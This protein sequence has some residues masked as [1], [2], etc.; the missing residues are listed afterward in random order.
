MNKSR[1]L[2]D[3]LDNWM[4]IKNLLTKDNYKNLIRHH[5]ESFDNFIEIKI[6]QIIKQ[7][8][9]LSIYHEYME[10]TNSYKYEIKINFMEINYIKPTI[11]ENDGSTKTM[12]PQDARLRN[13]TYSQTIMVDL[14]IEIVQNPNTESAKTLI[15]KRLNNINIGKVPVMVNSKFC[16][17]NNKLQN[18]EEGFYD[19]G[20][21]FII[22]GNEKVIVNQEKIAENKIY[23]FESTK[24][25]SKYSHICEI[26]SVSSK[27]FNTPKNVSVKLLSRE[28]M[29]G[30]CVRINIPH[31]KIEI[32]VFIVFKALG[33]I[34][35]KDIISHIVYNIGKED[36]ALLNWLR[37]NVEEASHIKTQEEA[38]EYLLRNGLILG[39][40]K[41]IKLDKDRKIEIFKAMLERDL[42][43]HI[44]GD[45]K[46][47]ALFL[48]YMVYKLGMC[49]LN[50]FKM[51]DRDNYCNK[52]I[53]SS[54]HLMA[55]LFRQYF[56][57]LIKDMRNSIMKELNSGP[58]K[59]TKNIEAVINSTNLFKMLKSTTLESGL[60]Y[61]LSTGNWGIKSTT[62]K[63]G[64]AQV[65]SR[66]TYVSTI[67]HLR[68]VNTPTE[69]TGKL[70]A[71][72]K[73]HNTQWGII[74]APETPEGGSVGLV[75]NLALST[76]ISVGTDKSPVIKVL[77]NIEDYINL[78]KF[79]EK[80]DI[81]DLYQKSKV[82]IN[83]EWIGV[84]DIPIKLYKKLLYFKRIGHINI[85]SSIS[86][87]HEINQI[88]IFTDAGRC[89][90]PLYIVENN[91]LKIKK[92]DI[93]KLHNNGYGINN[94][95]VKTLD[96][97]EIEEGVIEYVDTEESWNTM[98]ASNSESLNSKTITY[99]YCEIHPCLILGVLGSLIP[100]CNNNQSPRNTYQ[101]AMGK[102]AMGIYAT[103]FRHRM[104][105]MGHIL[106]YPQKP[107][108]NTRIANYLPTNYMPNG[109]NVIVAIAS[110]SG[111]NQE[112]SVL[113]KKSAVERGLFRST[114]YRTYKD[115]EKK[116]Q[117]S[118]QEEKFTIPDREL[119]KGMK[120]GCY[121][122]LDENGFVK[123]NKYVDTDDI[124][125]GKVIPLRKTNSK[126][127]YKDASTLLRNN[128]AGFVDKI[129]CNRNGDGH[130]FCKIRIRSER[131][132]KIGDKFSSRHGQKG[133]VGMIFNDEDMP[134]TK[135][136]ITPDVII[137]PH[138]IPSRM[139]I[140]QLIE[141]LL[142]KACSIIGCYGDGT[143]FSGTDINDISTI[144]KSYKYEEH[145]NEI[146]YDGFT[147]K[148]MSTKIFIGPTYYQRLKHMV[149]DKVH[150]RSTGPMVL[151]TRQPTEG[152]T[153]EG[154]LR[155][156]EMERD[157]MIAHGS[158]MFL[159]E[160]M[161][162]ISDNY[163]AFTCNSC[164]LLGI[165]NPEKNVYKCKKCNNYSDFSEIRIPYACKLM[166]QELESMSVAPRIITN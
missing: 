152:R 157:C 142:G 101:C 50:K 148:Q 45:F 162:D 153:R 85:Y 61:G 100:F 67:S 81:V 26:K 118:D 129:Y 66:I 123:L 155:F 58:W 122:K 143:P 46:K 95:V 19:L 114:F 84:T 14:N 74:C 10:E 138:A 127:I 93:D 69:K 16:M 139:T 104:D 56:T 17:L 108:V 30:R 75:K 98:I 23:V 36:D 34:S 44:G 4:V 96:S 32:P 82:F 134:Y 47:K 88:N 107:M 29:Y 18:K 146:L 8:N 27:G 78:D 28:N 99:S 5:I 102:Q 132:P 57:K 24:A 86:F 48:G 53:E 54:G 150:S 94:L 62:T 163:R 116:Y 37:P 137:N 111:Y 159:K 7:L 87:S 65:L 72:R 52:R 115:D 70:V 106:N 25:S 131:I 40:P 2:I 113:L 91:K 119:T 140:A 125:I 156:G 6:P 124:V 117:S 103:N 41:D 158:L 15:V 38:L 76:Y 83:G 73:L 105:T 55:L 79:L 42:L 136:G 110:Y 130:K 12:Y 77:D 64:I 39:Q 141:C 166:I 3:E 68:R 35:D 49:F 90:R 151:L 43:C 126:Y 13:F 31:V 80:Y 63:V 71:P 9:P 145:G 22:N 89:C 133:T 109:E 120:P 1:T 59:T 135:D 154:G 60:K 165:V 112:D 149:E 97:C 161:L 121:E 164:G 21:Y 92:E 33:I 11:Y 160:R 51:D 144:L 147:G 20:G 128:E